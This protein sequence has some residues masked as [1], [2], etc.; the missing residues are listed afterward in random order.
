MV[1]KGLFISIGSMTAGLCCGIVFTD[2]HTEIIP[3][4]SKIMLAG[5]RNIIFIGIIEER[6]SPS[7]KQAAKI[8]E[9]EINNNIQPNT[10]RTIAPAEAFFLIYPP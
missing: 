7:S 10:I 9:N 4:K 3:V 5:K 8:V 6:S 1:K 2:L